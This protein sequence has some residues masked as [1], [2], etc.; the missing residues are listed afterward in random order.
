MSTYT[1]VILVV[2]IHIEVLIN[3]PQFAYILQY[4][5]ITILRVYLCQPI[6]RFWDGHI[7]GLTF[8][9]TKLMTKPCI[10]NVTWG[11]DIRDSNTYFDKLLEHMKVAQ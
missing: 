1:G 4:I 8:L 5:S 6:N 10:S 2:Q 3:I 11:L 9:R 7:R